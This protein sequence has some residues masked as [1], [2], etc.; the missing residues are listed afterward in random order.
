MSTSIDILPAELWRAIGSI[1]PLSS[2]ARLM[3]ADSALAASGQWA[4]LWQQCLDV[5]D[6]AQLQ[7]IARVCPALSIDVETERQ[8]RTSTMAGTGQAGYDG[9]N[10]PARGAQLN[11]PCEVAFSPNGDLYIADSHNHRVRKVDA[12]GTITTIAGTGQPGYNGD[13]QPAPQAHLDRPGALAFDPHGNLHIADALNRRV[14]KVDANGTITTV[15]GSGEV[16]FDGDNQPATH[17]ALNYPCGLAFDPHG[18]LHIA[19]AQQHRVRKV[20]ATGIITTVAGTGSFG[21]NGDNRPAVRAQLRYPTALA[22]DPHG[23]LHLSDTYD[24]RVRT[25][26]ANGIINTLVGSGRYGHNGDNLPATRTWLRHPAALAFDSRGAL[27]FADSGNGR[28]RT[29]RCDGTVTTVAGSGGADP[30]AD[31][32]RP[33][34][35]GLS[36]PTDLA[37]A[38]DG[39]LYVADSAHHRI[40][41]FPLNTTT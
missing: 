17:A 11:Q 2:K 1:L 24:H 26:D 21:N 10:Q 30:V 41:R 28:I 22:F 14:R 19:D 35:A 12:N 18:N 29:V 39:S 16:M 37:F 8:H 5:A 31:G 27:Y 13:N 25:V 20:A 15:A 23:V 36:T 40:R 3:E 9:D 6:E 34:R 32:E 7:E 33:V 4:V 38:P